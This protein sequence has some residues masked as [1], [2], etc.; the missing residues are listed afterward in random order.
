M[1]RSDR[2]PSSHPADKAPHAASADHPAA[3]HAGRE[4]FFGLGQARRYLIAGI[5]VWVPVLVTWWVIKTLVDFLDRSLLLIPSAYRPETLLGFD[6]PGLGVILTFFILISTGMVA[7]NYFGRQLVHL[8]EFT[9]NRI[10]LVRSIYSAVKQILET[11]LSHESTTFRKVLLIEYPRRGCWSICF[12]SSIAQGEVQDR[13]EKELVTV[14]LPTVPNPTTGF[15]L[16]VPR[17]EAIEL[18]MSVDEAI[19][20][21]MSLGVIYPK[22]RGE[23]R[24]GNGPARAVPAE[25]NL[26]PPG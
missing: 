24:N 6:I 2:K 19:R 25:I 4:G 14:F 16:L 18:E 17:D 26:R 3:D 1:S 20:L 13:T 8:W 15:I 5:L 21:I 9:V 22:P 23:G 12:Q 10:P 11:F 7:A